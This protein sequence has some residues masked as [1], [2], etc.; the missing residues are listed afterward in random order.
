MTAQHQLHITPTDGDPITA[1]PEPGTAEAVSP[2]IKEL[3]D[4]VDH[5]A[6]L[7]FRTATG[8]TYIRRRAIDRI[9]ITDLPTDEAPALAD[10][11]DQG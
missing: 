8:W 3:L 2:S 11:G 4:R 6:M 5:E 7:G 10:C 1:T 9:D